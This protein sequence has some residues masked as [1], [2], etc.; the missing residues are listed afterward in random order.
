MTSLQNTAW[1]A[2]RLG[3]S[4]TTIERL[5]TQDPSQLPNSISIGRS[6][7]YDESTVEAWIQSASI[8]QSTKE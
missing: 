8:T 2:K 1:L 5:R 6:I 4:V 7:R 3:L